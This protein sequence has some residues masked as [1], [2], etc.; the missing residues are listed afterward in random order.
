MASGGRVVR[1]E[2]GT[3]DD[4]LF[5]SP[6]QRVAVVRSFLDV[7][8]GVIFALGCDGAI[9]PPQERDGLGAGTV[10]V[11]AE[12]GL[13]GA[14]GDSLLYRPLDCVVILLLKNNLEKRCRKW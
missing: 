14:G 2:G 6:Q 10:L 3:G 9:C 1:V 13:R 12:G 5:R 4:P 8:E 7:C 11:G